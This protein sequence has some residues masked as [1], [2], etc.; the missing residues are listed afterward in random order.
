MCIIIYSVNIMYKIKLKV[1]NL[2]DMHILHTEKKSGKYG[3]CRE[4]SAL[5]FE[6]VDTPLKKIYPKKT[7]NKKQNKNHNLAHG[8]KHTQALMSYLP[9]QYFHS[10]K[11]YF[12]LWAGLLKLWK[13]NARERRNKK[14]TLSGERML[15][16][17]MGCSER[18]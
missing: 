12:A 9:L 18:G 11:N 2:K 1:I 17:K 6:F 15:S 4:E 14:C 5:Q 8:L 13:Q 7:K 10:E 3:G 16:V